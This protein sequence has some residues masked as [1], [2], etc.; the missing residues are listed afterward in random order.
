MSIQD[1]VD[2]AYNIRQSATRVQQRTL[3]TADTL[4]TSQ[5]RLAAAVRGSRTGEQAV[6]QVGEA[7]RAVRDC[8]AKLLTLQSNIDRFIADITK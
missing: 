6:A 3:V 4:Q 8:S 7:Q 2:A 5:A 1:A